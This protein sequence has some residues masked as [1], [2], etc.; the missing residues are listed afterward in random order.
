MGRDPES[1]NRI[2]VTNPFCYAAIGANLGDLYSRRTLL[3]EAD[4][5]VA[6]RSVMVNI[7]YFAFNVY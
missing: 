3:P 6:G 5:I 1:I 4:Y 7:I 2:C